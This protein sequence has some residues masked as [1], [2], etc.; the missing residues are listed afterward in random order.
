MPTLEEAVAAAFEPAPAPAASP[1]EAPEATTA[2]SPP[3][4]ETP[5]AATTAPDTETEPSPDPEPTPKPEPTPT[6]PATPSTTDAPSVEDLQAIKA[7]FAEDHPELA[8]VMTAALKE[9]ERGLA[10]KFEQVAAL[11]RE[12][13][14]QIVS[15]ERLKGIP[16]QDLLQMAEWHRLATTNPQAAADHLF[17]ASEQLRQQASTQPQTPNPYQ[18]LPPQIAAELEEMRSYYR[19]QTQNQVVQQIEG[20]FS[21]LTGEFGGNAIPE[22]QRLHVL[23]TIQAK[24]LG[25]TEIPLMWKALY[26]VDHAR[27][28]ALKKGQA[29]RAQKA[30]LSAGS[31]AAPPPA[32]TP[33]KPKDL[34]SALDEV[35]S[36][37]GLR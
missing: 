36:S 27:Q 11:K 28:E 31:P 6:Q 19:Q 14:E 21:K 34:W 37:Q 17:A 5:V 22:N 15:D 8:P 3:N 12:A 20:E 7:R 18:Q 30:G 23:E 25:I 33:N 4:P 26:G 32:T 9:M 35:C 29:M 10:R 16:Q 2:E 13:A 24:G 1:G